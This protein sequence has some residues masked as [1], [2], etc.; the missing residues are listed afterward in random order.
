MLRPV[1]H[2]QAGGHE[3]QHD[4]LKKLAESVSSSRSLEDLTRP[5]LEMLEAVT[6][7][8]STYLTAIDLE[9]G[10]Q[11]I[12]FA[13]NAQTLQIPEGLSVPW[14]DT[15]CKRALE[16][17]RMFTDDVA[18]C[19][20]DSDAARELGIVTYV[21]T[22]VRTD[23]GDLYGTLCA[24]SGHAVSWSPEAARLLDMFA[25]MIGQQVER[26][27]LLEE[28][29]AAYSAMHAAALTDTLTG[30]PNRRRLLNELGRKL[31]EARRTDAAVLVTFVDLNGFKG[32][33]DAHG[34]AAGDELLTAFGQRLVSVSRAEDLVARFGGD[35]F[36]ILSGTVRDNTESL[37]AEIARR[38]QSAI[39]A[40]FPIAG[41]MIHCDAPSVGTVVASPDATVE[42][43]IALADTRMYEAKLSGRSAGSLRRLAVVDGSLTRSDSGI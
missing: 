41:Q 8:E 24:A 11:R 20:G 7:L 14:N 16:E 2:S 40:P 30:L 36:V 33:N 38:M 19:W 3:M 1:T 21:S 10:L 43:V 22:P 28:L 35:E 9:H 4:I 42:E 17:G 15:L 23:R 26:E 5:M 31:I 37:T 32:I 39:A 25:R 29:Q 13:R 6:G 27:Q 12:V 18:G 34:H